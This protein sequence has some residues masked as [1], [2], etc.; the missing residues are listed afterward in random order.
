VAMT[1]TTPVFDTAL[2]SRV[3]QGRLG[4]DGLD[5]LAA[6]LGVV[7]HGRPSALGDALATA[8]IFVRLLGLLQRRGIR[9]LG[10]AL[11]AASL[12]GRE[13]APDTPS[14]VRP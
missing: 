10:Q 9:T 14:E 7:V 2:L 11:D 6:R 5:Q 12:A 3:V 1:L 8:E 4:L 13:I